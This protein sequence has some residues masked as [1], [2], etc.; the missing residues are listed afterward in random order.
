[1]DNNV[2]EYTVMDGVTDL[3]T[4]E[5]SS[6]SNNGN[7]YMHLLSGDEYERGMPY[8]SVS[9]NI[10]PLGAYKAAIKT[11]DTTGDMIA[12][13][14]KNGLGERTGEVLHSG[15][16]TY[17]VFQFDS[18]VLRQLDPS[19]CRRYED[20]QKIIAVKLAK[21]ALYNIYNNSG[22]WCLAVKASSERDALLEYKRK[23]LSSGEYSIRKTADG[24]R[25]VSSYGGE[26]RAC[27]TIPHSTA[28]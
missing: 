23:L 17:P 3:V 16:C 26:W 1:M 2:F 4:F 6:Y 21:Q 28:I 15:H 14:E 9:V 7:L 24:Y 10:S 8:G 22:K 11:Y 18:D 20:H 13:L 19:G 25:L 27:K 12:F 5:I